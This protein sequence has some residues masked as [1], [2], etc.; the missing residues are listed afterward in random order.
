[1]CRT[2]QEVYTFEVPIRA[3]QVEMYVLDLADRLGPGA[4][5]PGERDLAT[6]CGVSRMTVRRAL[7]ELAARRVIER[8]HGAGTFVRRPE[9]AQPLMA[10]SFH[11]DMRRRG[12]EPSSRL[13]AATAETAD[14]ESAERLEIAEG[15]PVLVVRRVRLADDEPMALET[16]HIPLART[17]GLTGDDL[18]AGSFYALLRE[19]FGRRVTSGRQIVAPAVP[20][21]ADAALLDVESG[22]P[23]FRFVRIT[24][25]QN[26]EVVEYVDALYRGDRYLIEVDL[27]PPAEGRR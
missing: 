23:A 2:G 15:D 19:R 26:D 5:L 18:V 11:E 8:R 16:L 6:A 12:Y 21:P 14:A 13:V 3:D 4:L 24:R 25:D 17:P 22:S 10:T 7:D 9:A 1:L 20:S 27:L